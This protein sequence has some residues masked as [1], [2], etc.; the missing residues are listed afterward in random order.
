MSLT[1]EEQRQRY[2][3]LLGE[4]RTIIPGAQVLLAFLFTV[5]FSSRFV[6]VD[7]LGRVV[8][9]VSLVSVA[10]AT[11]L[12]VAPAAY[13]RLADPQDRQARLRFGIRTALWGL[14]LLALSITCAIFVVVRFL[15]HSDLLGLGVAA[16]I[17]LLAFSVWY[18]L[19]IRR[20]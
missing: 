11:V 20:R 1:T 10:V 17:A 9:T 7:H 6:E 12:F 5:P 4:L 14:A 19:P 18:I 2:Q 13:H 8:F 15:F 16:A 3:E